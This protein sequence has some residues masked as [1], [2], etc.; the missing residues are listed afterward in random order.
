MTKEPTNA[1]KGDKNSGGSQGMDGGYLERDEVRPAISPFF[2]ISFKELVS[3]QG[4]TSGPAFF[5]VNRCAGSE[6]G[7][8]S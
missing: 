7:T 4:P 2:G 3:D 8:S 1:L 6:H 5:C